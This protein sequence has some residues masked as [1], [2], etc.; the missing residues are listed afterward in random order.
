L[1]D[2]V[3]EA[4][5]ET[6]AAKRE[7]FTRLD[8]LCRPTA[9]LASNTSSLRIAEMAEA[10]LHPERVIGLHFFNPVP[11][12]PLVEVVRA[13]HSDDAALA[14][15][16]ALAGRIGKTPI[17]V[18]DAPGFVVNRV[19]IPY[20]GEALVMAGEGASVPAI[21]L[22]MKQWG[23]PMGPFELLDEI[24]LDVADHVL[25]SLH[26]PPSA[27]LDRA[28]N[29]KWLGKKT[30][31]G[32]YVYGKRPKGKPVLN[33]E[34]VESVPAAPADRE[35][36]QSRLLRPMIDA[37]AK[38]LE[39]GVTDSADTIDLATVLGLGLAPF[40]GGLMHLVAQ[41]PSAVDRS[42]MTPEE[43]QPRAAVPHVKGETD[44]HV[45]TQH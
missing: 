41:P 11:K 26:A 34:L 44:A 16:I 35:A 38:L 37:A 24:G 4:V 5:V 33:R 39:E 31:R 14:T 13:P 22:I 15:A 17:L 12:M 19:L 28:L 30:G 45:Q 21:D 3:I 43:A 29:Q 2:F 23:M 7:I 40:R 10:T 9:V 8:R 20:L 18:N 36:V 27:L 6:I 25:K 1:A 32:F 42:T